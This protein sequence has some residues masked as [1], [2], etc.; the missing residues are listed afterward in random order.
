MKQLKPRTEIEL[1][2]ALGHDIHNV[3]KQLRQLASKIE[4]LTRR[5]F[6]IIAIP[7]TEGQ[8]DCF[9]LVHLEREQAEVRKIIQNS[10]PR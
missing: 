4:R 6:R 3:P 1:P 7:R 8:H 10:K 2:L 9:R 5:G